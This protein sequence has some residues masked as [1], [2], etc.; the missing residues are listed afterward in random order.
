MRRLVDR[1]QRNPAGPKPSHAQPAIKRAQKNAFRRRA[2]LSLTGDQTRAAGLTATEQ[3]Y[4][5][6]TTHASAARCVKRTG[7]VRR[8]P[9]ATPSSTRRARSSP[10]HA[11][12]LSVSIFPHP[13]GSSEAG[14]AAGFGGA[15]T[16]GKS[17]RKP[18]LRGHK[19]CSRRWCLGLCFQVRYLREVISVRCYGWSACNPHGYW[20]WAITSEGKWR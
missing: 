20:G 3:A 9:A 16:A 7:M 17:L 4:P 10:R 1:G 19:W 11:P 5:H 14:H 8:R 15:E 6:P 18:A 12:G 2:P 13:C